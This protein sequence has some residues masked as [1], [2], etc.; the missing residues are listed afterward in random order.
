MTFEKLCIILESPMPLGEVG[1]GNLN[2]QTNQDLL[3]LKKIVG[4][5][6]IGGTA[7]D[8]QSINNRQYDTRVGFFMVY[9]NTII[10]KYQGEIY[11]DGVI[12]DSTQTTKF[13]KGYSVMF[14]FYTQFLLK[15]YKF[16]ISDDAL[17]T[18][19][20]NFYRK[21][22]SRFTKLGYRMS[23]IKIKPD[24]ISR[25]LLVRD[26]VDIYRVEELSKYYNESGSLESYRYKISK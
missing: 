4:K 3:S 16:V 6:N 9:D 22:F 5:I 25:K 18:D 20:Y 1:F 12:T 17:S 8:I 26:E 14:E 13:I 2:K 11:Q 24:H 21:N 23:A 7:V 15:N 19:G 10:G